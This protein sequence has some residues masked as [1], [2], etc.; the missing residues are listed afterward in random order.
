MTTEQKISILIRKYGSKS[1]IRDNASPLSGTEGTFVNNKVLP[2]QIWVDLKSIPDGK[3]PLL[4]SPVD[5]STWPSGSGSPILVKIIK[6]PLTWIPGT[7]A[8][9]DPSDPEELSTVKDVVSPDV[10]LTY[11]PYVY[12]LN[13]QSNRYLY[14]I[15]PVEYN[16]IFDYETGCLVFVDGIPSFMKSP[17]FQ[18]PAI[19][20]YK[21]IGRKTAVGIS[22]ELIQGSTGPTGPRGETGPTEVSSMSWRGEYSQDLSY[23]I[24]DV[25]YKDGI[26]WVKTTGPTGPTDVTSVYFDSITYNELVDGF[27]PTLNEQYVDVEYTANQPPYFESL[28]DISS[29]ILSGIVP[30]NDQYKNS[31]QNI[32]VFNTTGPQ[33]LVSMTPPPYS[34]RLWFFSPK[35]HASAIDLYLEGS[36]YRMLSVEGL[37]SSDVS[38]TSQSF[39]NISRSRISGSSAI[40]SLTNS[41]VVT[42]DVTDIVTTLTDNL[43][44]SSDVLL[45][46]STRVNSCDFQG[47]NIKLSDP[48]V[49]KPM[50]MNVYGGIIHYF[51]ESRFMDTT[52]ELAY[53]GEY[54]NLT[55]VFDKCRIS[56]LR[57]D[58]QDAGFT[59]P[60]RPAAF[61]L[62]NPNA[63]QIRIFFIDST[64]T[65]DASTY[66]L[67]DGSRMVVIGSSVFP[68]IVR[69]PQN[70]IAI[71][72]GNITTD[73][74]INA[75]LQTQNSYSDVN[76]RI[77][78]N[79]YFN[80]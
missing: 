3:N 58:A 44:E 18:P 48:G 47:C 10:H 15:S 26:V 42:P 50:T 6:K 40:G 69:P 71:G 52:F 51:K 62:D 19:T 64:V 22:A 33:D 53:T 27:I 24:D 72:S 75:F 56:D 5:L 14:N 73:P 20:C 70:T 4:S 45:C 8:F 16:W 78:T 68:P 37:R 79:F 11:T 23:S 32:N 35:K 25:V 60:N 36:G 46:G 17:Q 13:T 57:I 29:S 54:R 1:V 59:F 41:T 9:Y 80:Q 67:I 74:T 61:A 28:G 2:E 77:T 65:C 43:F 76:P 12:L 55:I 30:A 31:D 21:Y 49:N 7:N 66:N 34:N 63:V 38:V 39:L